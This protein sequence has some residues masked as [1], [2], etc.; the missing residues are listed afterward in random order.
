MSRILTLIVACS[1]LIA[2]RDTTPR[3]QIVQVL[4]RGDAPP[5]YVPD[6]PP[7]LRAA[8]GGR[9][10]ANLPRSVPQEADAVP[11]VDADP[12]DAGLEPDA[13]PQPDAGAASDASVPPDAESEPDAAPA[14]VPQGEVCNA[15]DDDCDGAVDEEAA[16]LN[17]CGECGAAPVEE[18]NSIDDD[19]DGT[20]D[21][22]VRNA[23]GGC[24]P[25]P[26]E[27]CNAIDDD[28]DGAVDETFTRLGRACNGG[29]G[30]CNGG[31]GTVIC[32]EDGQGVTCS[33][34][35]LPP[36][37]EE[38]CDGRDNDCDGRTDETF[39]IG[40]PCSVGRGACAA[41]GRYVCNAAGDGA[42]CPVDPGQP[43]LEVCDLIDNDC[44]GTTDEHMPE[45]WRNACGR[46]G[47][48]PEEV[49][50]G[51][52]DDC[53]GSTDEGFALDGECRE[54]LSAICFADGV[55]ICASPE[56]VA[57]SVVAPTLDA[58]REQHRAAITQGREFACLAREGRLRCWGAHWGHHAQ[59]TLGDAPREV[60]PDMPVVD[61]GMRISAVVADSWVGCGISPTGDVKCW[62][63]NQAGALGQGDR[64]LR[65]TRDDYGAALPPIPLGM[66]AQQVAL[67]GLRLCAVGTEGELK[68]WGSNR[69]NLLMQGDESVGDG[70]DEVAALES[71]DLGIEVVKVAVG[72]L[73]IC[74]LGAEGEVKCW[75]EGG[76]LA[77]GDAQPRYVRIDDAAELP[78][79]RIGMHAIDIDAG[80]DS[81][82]AVGVDGRVKCWG[83]LMTGIADRTL[84]MGDSP[85]E[86]EAG[87]PALPFTIEAIGVT[88][89]GRS[90]CAWDADGIVECVGMRQHE[91]L[92]GPLH[93]VERVPTGMHVIAM[94][95]NFHSVCALGLE[96]GVKCWGDNRMGQLGQG[97]THPRSPAQVERM[98]ALEF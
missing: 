37:G 64:R 23:C 60:G 28:C 38:V 65:P 45:A 8:P 3:G 79:A 41:H 17:A 40:Q 18:C 10:L 97:D 32:A 87:L 2:C 96:G 1:A 29:A 11:P 26:I 71:I 25:T 69:N 30:V 54:A 73:H 21:E 80:R 9:S 56:R 67:H 42:F 93:P 19:C 78:L 88:T 24:G 5:T 47:P 62:G 98:P 63:L 90:T 6:A 59:E 44:D 39:D 22:G 48:V 82:C 7:S 49:C 95:Q 36:E 13:T 33:A 4:P 72:G 83:E 43:G 53:D 15:L 61:L 85:D 66:R 14:C 57:C 76:K 91:G 16:D 94:H 34:P 35:V 86:I 31:Q 89:S 51:F 92:I 75:G 84:T 50:N 74:A 12:P 58:C 27:R 70:P 77:A 52:D 68:C 46:C 20:I 81:T 55:P